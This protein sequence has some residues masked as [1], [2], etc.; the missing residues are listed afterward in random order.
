M[1]DYNQHANGRSLRKY[2]IDKGVDYKWLSGYKK[3]YAPMKPKDQSAVDEAEQ[4]AFV[5][6]ETIDNALG[7]SEE[8]DSKTWGVSSMTLTSPAGDEIEIKCNNIAAVSELLRK[9][10]V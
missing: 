3:S 4:Q 5:K 1:Q 10:S 9:M 8:E 2:C 6:L 7:K